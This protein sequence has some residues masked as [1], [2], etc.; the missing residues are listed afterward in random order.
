[1]RSG[2][3]NPLAV[4]GLQEG[5]SSS[6]LLSGHRS[7]R[8]GVGNP[9]IA[10]ESASKDLIA[11]PTS[12]LLLAS[13][14]GFDGIDECGEEEIVRIKAAMGRWKGLIPTYA[15]RK[16][17]PAFREVTQ[18][19]FDPKREQFMPLLYQQAKVRLPPT[20]LAHPSPILPLLTHMPLLPEQTDQSQYTPRCQCL[21]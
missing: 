3:R 18:I 15:I 1:M 16:Q 21:M 4:P 9:S 6:R 12:R 20:R 11:M 5:W 13:Q 8:D 10:N 19:H 7:V 17:Q 2:K 14:V